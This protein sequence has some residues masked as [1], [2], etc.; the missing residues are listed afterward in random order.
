LLAGGQR[1]AVRLACI[2]VAL[3]AWQ[4]LVASGT[5]SSSAVAEPTAILKSLARLGSTDP[6]WSSIASTLRTW[7]LGLLL[8]LLIAIP[9]GLLLG[10]SD[11]AYRLS[12]FTIDFLRTIPPVALMPVALLLYGATDKMAIILIVFGSVWPVLL[13]CMYGVHDIDPVA[14]DVAMSYRWRRREVV[15]RLVMPSAAPFVATGIRIAATTSLLLAIGSELI[16]GAPG[17]GAAIEVQNESGNISTVYAYVVVCGILGV[18]LN[19]AMIRAERRIL[20]WH[21]AYR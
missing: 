1:W 7:S 11:L 8:S 9:A 17:I 2:A 12:R 13:Q 16:G 15:T 14:R 20:R 6:F 5:L 21:S 10:S 4:W 18:L 3:G 19:L